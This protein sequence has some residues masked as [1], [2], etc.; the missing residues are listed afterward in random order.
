MA[1]TVAFLTILAFLTSTATAELLGSH[2]TIAMVKMA[3]PWGFLLLVPALAIT[4]ASGFR[5]AG[6]SA[7]PVILRKKRRMPLI[8]ANGLLILVPAAFWLRSLASQG[9]FGS[10]FYIV[11]AIELVAGSVNLAFMALNIRDGLQLSG[12]WP[13]GLVATLRSRIFPRARSGVG[14]RK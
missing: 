14:S 4:G 6:A 2:A 13:R 7:D 12:R 1:G 3:I 9:D 5:M 10:I 11:Q 8:A